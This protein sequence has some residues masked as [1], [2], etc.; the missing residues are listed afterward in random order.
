MAFTIVLLDVGEATDE[1]GAPAF[2]MARFSITDGRDTYLW[3]RGHIPL[4][5]D[6]LE[7]LTG[8]AE[9]LWRFASAYQEPVDVDELHLRD[10]RQQARAELDW[11]SAIIPAIDDMTALQVR[12]V[13]KRLAQQNA[14]LITSLMFLA[15]RVRE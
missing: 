8:E 3:R 2:N 11:L 1:L 4:D 15:K 9:V 10:F 6:V 13:V 7:F 14:Q 5:T 12:G